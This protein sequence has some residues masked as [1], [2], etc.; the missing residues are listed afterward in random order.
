MKILTI[1]TSSKNAIVVITENEEKIVELNNEEEKTHSQK[2]MP[3][4]EE[5][6]QK[7]KLCLD[8]IELIVCCLG[9]GSFTG[10]RIGI[11]TAKAFADSKNIPV[12]G[13][14]ALEGLAYNIEEEGYICSFIDA[15]HGNTYAGFF[16]IEK[17]RELQQDLTFLSLTD[18]N[19]K[20]TEKKLIAFLEKN[21]KEE[22]KPI[23]FIG[24]SINSY[25]EEFEKLKNQ[26]D[27]EK[28]DQKSSLG[29]TLAKIGYTKYKNGKSGNSSI[30]SPIYLRKSQA[31]LALEEKKEKE[32]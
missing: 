14:N 26:N 29:I 10:V 19:G 28:V 17:N 25:A 16:E 27:Y 2:L 21:T 12:V 31:E 7:S 23:Y 18:E 5:A 24:D 20:I 3:M 15:G 6:F 13:V 8:D 32:K 1:D 4:I 30:L 11:A 9:P 22:N